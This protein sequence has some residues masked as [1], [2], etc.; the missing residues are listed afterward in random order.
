MAEFIDKGKELVQNLYSN[1]NSAELMQSGNA[2]RDISPLRKKFEENLAQLLAWQEIKTEYEKKGVNFDESQF[3]IEDEL[4]EKLEGR[5]E[6]IKKDS[7]FKAIIEGLTGKQMLDVVQK[8]KQAEGAEKGATWGSIEL[9]APDEIA[10]KVGGRLKRSR[11]TLARL[12][13]LTEGLKRSTSSS[14]TGKLKS[15]FVGNTEEY[16]R[17][18]EAMQGIS[19]GTMSKEDAKKAIT[20]YLDLRK[21][22]V[23][24]HQ[25]GRDRFDGFMKG[26]Q[27]IMEPEEF[28]AYC[29]GVDVAR[30]KRDPDYRGV[31]APEAYM[32]E[33]TA[34]EHLEE[35]RKTAAERQLTQRELAR[36]IAV[37][38]IVN[39]EEGS[40]KT[41]IVPRD[42][43]AQ[44]EN[45]LGNENFK[46][47]YGRQD[48]ETLRQEIAK[49]PN[50]A[51]NSLYRSM[52]GE[53]RDR[54]QREQQR[55]EREEQRKQE[56]DRRQKQE[57][58][59]KEQREQRQKQEQK[60]REDN[61]KKKLS[62]YADKQMPEDRQ[63]QTR[64]YVKKHPE[65][66]GIAEDFAKQHPKSGLKLPEPEK[67]AEQ[68]K[69][70]PQKGEPQG[71]QLGG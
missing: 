5:T 55:A 54:E 47:W 38:M 50:Y 65:L 10:E 14:F 8:G 67:E 40:A 53:Q 43:G 33:K 46:T 63:Q 58:Y 42:L 23:R 20:T 64:D 12:T 24:N 30:R 31:T 17:A 18:Y 44:V 62:M 59:D 52:P 41:E 34:G 66:R 49:D 36:L 68:Q 69:G 35:M 2:E 32:P 28:E 37:N 26:L 6:E 56:A 29:K 57:A 9:F 4:Q 71:P 7:S 16:G 22:K 21:K 60:N 61:F 3:D 48:P 15:W 19:A 51:A 70:E 25:Y 27:T 1:A 45:L 13:G 39:D 11:E